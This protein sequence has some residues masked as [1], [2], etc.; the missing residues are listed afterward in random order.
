M[1]VFVFVIGIL[2]VG[3]AVALG[4][5]ASHYGEK[6]KKGL[7]AL[8]ATIGLGVI[9]ISQSFVIVPTGSAGVRVSFGQVD[10]A[11]VFQGVNWK[12]PFVQSIETISTKQHDATFATDYGFSAESKEKITVTITNVTVT[13]AINAEMVPWLVA[14]V[15]DKDLVS[16]DI[17]SAGL[18]EATQQLTVDQVTR[19]EVLQPLAVERIQKALDAKYG[20]DVIYVRAVVINNV[21]YDEAYEQ[22][23]SDRARAQEAQAQQAIINQTNID[24]ATAEAEAARIR[25]QGE[26]DALEIAAAAQAE[27]NRLIAESITPEMIEWR[28]IEAIGEW[29]PYVIGGD[30][31]P[32]VQLPEGMTA[33]TE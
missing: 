26:A 21:A 2:L 1:S 13:Y 18:K 20:A 11:P 17:V 27:A 14:N 7:I 10:T 23:I 32:M 8:L 15:A 25:A 4:A 19:R 3:G 16:A 6:A 31:L 22:A 30:A 5:Y 33:P 24:Q 9:I 28:W 12:L 29:R